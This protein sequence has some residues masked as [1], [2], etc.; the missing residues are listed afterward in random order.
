MIN[1]A[2]VKK[3]AVEARRKLLSSVKAKAGLI[4]VTENGIA[5]PITKGQGYAVYPTDAGIETTLAGKQLEQRVNLVK[6]INEIA[7]GDKAEYKRAYESVMEEAAY[8]WF[9]RIIAVRFMEI[10]GYLPSGIRVLSSEAKDKIEPDIVTLAP[11]IDLPLSPQEIDEIISL[12]AANK[13]DE[14]FRML[15][16]KQCNELGKLLPGLFENTSLYDRDYTEILL[17]ISYTN[18]DGV[19]RSLLE[20]DE[21]YFLDQ[22]EIIGWM[23]QYY[24]SEKH[25]EVIDIY[26][27]TAVKKEDIPAAT[28][29]FTP[30]WIVR[31]M[32]DNSLGR[33]WMERYPES[34]LASK[35]KFFIND[36]IMSVN[37]K[38][39]PE[40]IKVLD[41]CMGS[42]HILVYAFDVLMQIYE[43]CG[44]TQRDAA[45]LIVEKNLYGLDI[46]DRAYQLAYFAVMMRGRKY[47]RRFLERG[48]TPNLCAIKES[49][50]LQ[51]FGSAANELKICDQHK[52]TA[53][54]LIDAFRDAKE[55]G[56]ILN[57]E[58]MDYDGLLECLDE[59]RANSDLDINYQSW[60][61][62]EYDLML[63]LIKQ[64]KIMSQKYDIVVTNP[65]YL[66]KMDAKLKAFVNKN[67]KDYS[68]DLFS[69][70]IYRNFGFCKQNGYCAFMSPFVWMFIKTY[71]ELRKYI[72]RNK[73]I[74][75]LIQ[76]EYSAFEE[77]TVPLC[78]FVLKNAKDDQNG[79]YIKLSDFKG[80]MEIQKQKTLEA[81]RNKNCG[82]YYKANARNFERIPGMPIAYWA[83]YSILAV[84]S[85]P[86]LY[87]YT[88]SAGQN[89]TGNNAIYL[90]YFWEVTK[91]KVGQY[92]KWV[93]YAKGGGYKKWFGN[94]VNLVNWMPEARERYDSV[95]RKEYW[96]KKGITWGLVTS[97][98]PSFRVLP[99]GSTFDKG[100]SSI[101]VKDDS[102]FN[103]ILGLL[104]SKVFLEIVQI[105]NPT[106]N[107]Q[108]K[109][110]RSMPVIFSDMYKPRVDELVS[111]NIAISKTDWDSFE[112]SW[113]FKKHP[114]IAW[115]TDS[116]LIKDA[117][118]NWADF[119]E[120]Q[121]AQLKANEE[122]LNRIF[123][124]IYGLQG[125]LTPDIEDKDV[126]VRKA[127]LQRDIRSFISYA[128]GC[129]FGRYSL[130]VDGLAYAGGEWDESRYKTFMPD[131]DNIL[132]I[133]DEEYFSD[134]I[135]ARFVEF[136]KAA[137]GEDTLSQ[138]LA[139]IASAL[140]NKDNTPREVIRNYFLKNF[141]KDHVKIY[142]KRPIYWMFDSGKENAFKALIYLHRYDED[143]V[144]RVRVDYLHK[145]QAAIESA[146]DHCD[147]VQSVY[148]ASPAD[149]AKAMGQ[150]K[151]LVKQLAETRLYDQAIAHI[152]LQRIRLDLD[153]G[154]A[155]NYAKF[156]GVEVSSEG[157]KTIKIDLL[158]KI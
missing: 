147:M 83:T 71:E 18:E 123:I 156:Q 51:R 19:I 97:R 95:V 37:E 25:D 115:K 34:G 12:K 137:Y 63:D 134:D 143:T 68:R 135:V 57:V 99:K 101:F 120:R 6:R 90:R 154:V 33:Y 81:I 4:G 77:A 136:V 73:N 89:V 132:P 5:E 106:L 49:D 20:L 67:Y 7:G 102:N 56:A 110:I 155:V 88:V 98:V 47:D 29:L 14:L 3:F 108:I 144:G 54:Y 23:Y 21:S 152:A 30:D 149:K 85:Y 87:K 140:G 117:F 17:D 27:A 80:G 39:S 109:D 84:F 139:F 36:Q 128:V 124:E 113:D 100:G 93:F 59:I 79:I 86:L 133:T 50:G 141:Y 70:F 64:A 2:E 111:Q 11:D 65:P 112:T 92:N 66:S 44:Y 126:T 28:Q 119:A 103:Y 43:S 118:D 40:D 150:K 55:Y 145:A 153:D 61:R 131:K 104:N 10:N 96:Y 60:L 26:G 127:D 13:L 121:F 22:V 42:G 46:D 94:L 82:Y 78:T 38:T 116:G 107:F 58:P 148:I 16:I 146:I 52:D 125:E 69:V 75:S 41:P 158:A 151:K 35:L 157:K 9:N 122:E 72:I 48:I 32:I 45:R 53:N 15:F 105:F 142:K 138:N 62:N 74:S 24:I 130:D 114:L 91:S 129:M 31:Y 8:T 76:M 1:K